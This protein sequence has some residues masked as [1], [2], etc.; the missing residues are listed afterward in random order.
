MSSIN[1]V[2]L[3]GNLTRDAEYRAFQ[4][5][6]GG[7]LR[8]G[9]ASNEA[10]KNAGTGEWEEYAHFFDCCLFGKRAEKLQ[11]YLRKGTKVAVDGSLRYTAWKDPETGAS[12]SKVEI[13]VNEVEFLSGKRGD[14]ATAPQADVTESL[15]KGTYVTEVADAPVGAYSDVDIPF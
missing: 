1:R 3:T 5:G 4:S 2:T 12:R 15:P 8:F 13:K 6:N 14:G 9:I 10:R 7:V 11:Q